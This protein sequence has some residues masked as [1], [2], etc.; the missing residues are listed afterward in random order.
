MYYMRLYR[1][2]AKIKCELKQKKTKQNENDN[3]QQQ[4][5]PAHPTLPTCW[6]LVRS[7]KQVSFSLRCSHWGRQRLPLLLRCLLCLKTLGYKASAF[8]RKR[9]VPSSKHARKNSRSKLLKTLK[10]ESSAKSAN[11]S[12]KSTIERTNRSIVEVKSLAACR[13]KD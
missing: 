7:S 4:Q 10:R 5:P 9:F 6:E 12:T 2:T 3:R 11:A 8:I 13:V 1:R